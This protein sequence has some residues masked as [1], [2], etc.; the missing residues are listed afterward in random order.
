ME[1]SDKEHLY[2]KLIKQTT[3]PGDVCP[4]ED[5]LVRWVQKAL[6]PSECDKMEQH[7]QGCRQCAEAASK[8]TSARSWFQEHESFVFAGIIEKAAREGIQPWASCPSSQILELYAGDAIS[9]DEVGQRFRHSLKAHVSQ[10]LSCGHKYIN[11]LHELKE[12]IILKL[13]D[14]ADSA[15]D[16]AISTLHE[17]LW[18]LQT[19]AIA[20]G[21]GHG[22]KAIPGYRSGDVPV[23]EAIQLNRENQ[24]VLDD[25]AQPVKTAFNVI[26][27]EI[28]HDGHLVLDLVTADKRYWEKP[29]CRFMISAVLTYRNHKVVLPTEK[30][31]SD[32][33][34]TFVANLVS[35]VEIRA[36]PL[37]SIQL[38][39]RKDPKET[40]ENI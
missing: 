8:L 30:I 4:T 13:E 24:L 18:G 16:T 23:L 12:K 22:V 9:R 10:C 36:I 7:M 3:Y 14:L 28:E 2:K 25:E 27:A 15:I 39:I 31:Y 26:R 29:G 32:G 11:N 34:V 37:S 21:T 40:T 19:Q 20:Q 35:G 1:T 6:T 5:N 17:L 33:R 38:S